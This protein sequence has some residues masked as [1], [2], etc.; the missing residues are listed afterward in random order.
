PYIARQR[1][2]TSSGTFASLPI[3]SSWIAASEAV[4]QVETGKAARGI[5]ENGG[6]C[7]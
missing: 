1:K 5:S 6:G 2:K 7:D 3:S 4:D